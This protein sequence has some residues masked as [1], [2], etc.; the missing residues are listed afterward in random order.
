MSGYGCDRCGIEV[1]YGGGHYLGDARV[2]GRCAA[3][4]TKG[5][6]AV[7]SGYGCDRCGVEVAF[8]GGH[9]LGDARVCATCAAAA[10][11]KSQVR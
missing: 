4:E 5:R 3:G 9:Y 11:T 10:E 6:G 2:C 7:A 8:G 1:V